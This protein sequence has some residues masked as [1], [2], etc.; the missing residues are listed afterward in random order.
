MV[1]WSVTGEH[2]APDP[3]G[4]NITTEPST[5]VYIQRPTDEYT[6]PATNNIDITKTIK[7]SYYI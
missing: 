7:P 3:S 2:T 6:T 1:P 5:M 4:I